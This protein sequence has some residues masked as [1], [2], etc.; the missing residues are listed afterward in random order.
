MDSLDEQRHLH[1][2][3]L[4][5]LQQQLSLRDR[6]VARVMQE[7]AVMQQDMSAIQVKSQLR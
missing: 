6:Q 3:G 7:R 5:Q 4:A 2:Q 1:E